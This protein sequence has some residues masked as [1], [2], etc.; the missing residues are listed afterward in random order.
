MAF[1]LGAMRLSPAE[2]WATTPRELAAAMRALGYGAHRP[3]GRGELDEMMRR[4]PD[5]GLAKT[6]GDDLGRA[7]DHRD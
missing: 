3:P 6:E 2:F 4:H 1:G 5:G 7:S